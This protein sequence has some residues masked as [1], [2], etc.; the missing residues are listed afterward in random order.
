MLQIRDLHYE[1]GDRKLLNGVDW[2][3]QAGK[4]AALIGPNGAGKTTMLR[5]LTGEIGDYHGSIITPKGY[6]IGYLPQEE[7]VPWH[8]SILRIVLQGRNEALE[9]EKTLAELHDALNAPDAHHDA[10]LEQ[11]GHLEHRYDALDGYRLE[12]DA[13]AILAGL[14]FQNA[15]YERPLREFS[16]GWGM[17]VHLARLLLQKP[18]LLLMDEP[19]NHLDIP[20]LEWLERYLLDFAGSVVIVS[21]DRF[22]VDR[23]A[24][25]IYELDRGKLE[26]YAGNY[27]FYEREK[28]QRLGLLRKRWQEQQ[29]EREKQEKFIQRF[30]YKATKARQVQSR[31][32]Q[33]ENMETIELPPPPRRLDFHIQVTLPSYKDV[34]HLK[35]MSFRYETDWVLQD[36]NLSLYRGEKIAMVGVN[37]AGKTTMTRVIAKE[38]TPQQGRVEIGE[39]VTLGYY[40]Q[41]QVDA[42]DLNASIY[43]EV[44]STAADGYRPRVR[45]ILGLFQFQGDDIYKKIGVLSGGEKARVSLTKILLSPVNFLIMDEPTNHLD[46]MSKEALEHAL[47]HYDGTLIL[48]SHDRYFLDKIVGRVVEL[49]HGHLKQFAGNYSYYLEKRDSESDLVVHAAVKAEGLSVVR[50]NKEQKRLEAEARQMISKERNRLRKLVN[51]LESTIEDMEAQ[52]EALEFAMAAPETYK[53]SERVVKLQ[54]EHASVKKELEDFYRQWEEA[55]LEMEALMETLA[56]RTV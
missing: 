7:I 45:D 55:Q 35:D 47:V 49:Q 19:T 46:M 44:V 14:G 56:E 1:I 48:I 22:F 6:Q 40:A 20:S 18:D 27:H 28:E 3:L 4:R 11:I 50:K 53:E 42:L 52:K 12:A 39:R 10:L 8:G 51:G 37:G 54:K 41:H 43:D 32:K 15:D 31:V 9:I 30:R 34:L 5:I 16:G 33:L 23:L 38:L 29:A 13:K 26:E 2:I 21:H 25:V 36:V 17:R 24:E